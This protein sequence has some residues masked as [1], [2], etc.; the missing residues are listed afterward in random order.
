MLQLITKKQNI[1]VLFIFF[2]QHAIFAHYTFCQENTG[3][4]IAL[5]IE[6]MRFTQF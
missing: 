2:I 1:S 6:W 3:E 4:I 5:T